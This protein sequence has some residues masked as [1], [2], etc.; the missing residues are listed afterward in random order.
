MK[1]RDVLV[2]IEDMYQYGM[3][4]WELAERLQFDEF[5]DNWQAQ[6]AVIRALEVMGEA[7]RYVPESFR[8]QHP[9][10]PWRAIVGLRNILI[11]RYFDLDLVAVWQTVH[12][13]L[14]GVLQKLKNLLQESA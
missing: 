3:K 7:A 4:A 13:V 2:Y 12:D 6:F 14:P 8:Q 10:I 9:E 5:T 11:H 1:E